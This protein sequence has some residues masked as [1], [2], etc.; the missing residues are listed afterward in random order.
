[1]RVEGIWVKTEKIEMEINIILF[2]LCSLVLGVV[3]VL[4]IV[5]YLDIERKVRVVIDMLND[6][7]I[8]KA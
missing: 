3:K 5:L 2:D 7:S 1:M 6:D 8:N 4:Q